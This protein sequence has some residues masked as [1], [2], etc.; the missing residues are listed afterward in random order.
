LINILYLYGANIFNILIIM[1]RP[2]IHIIST[3]RLLYML[4]LLCTCLMKGVA[5]YAQEKVVRVGWY[6]SPLCHKDSLGYRSG[7]AYEY[8]MKI[9][10]STKW[11]YEYVEG[12]WMELLQ[13][14]ERGEIDLLS[15]VSVSDERIKKMLFSQHEMGRDE[16]YIYTL[17]NNQ[18]IRRGNIA[19]LAGKRVGTVRKGIGDSMLRQWAANNDVQLTIVDTE[20][21]GGGLTEPLVSGKLDGVVIPSSV[22]RGEM[23]P[24]FLIGATQVF[25]AINKDRMDIKNELDLAMSQ[26]RYLSPLYTNNLYEKY[27][28]NAQH[29]SRVPDSEKRWFANHKTI[30]IGYRDDYMPFSAKDK[31]TG[32]IDGLL[33][34]FINL[35]KDAFD[36][37][38]FNIEAVAYTS[39]REALEAMKRG[40]VD[41]AFPLDLG[42]SEA[43]QEGLII[44]DALVNSVEMAI[45]RSDF[46]FKPHTNLRVAINSDNP[47]YLSIL[48]RNHPNWQIVNYSSTKDC[49]KGIANDE[50][51]LL[52][53]SNYRMGVLAE[54]I[55]DY[56]L[57]T[58]PTGMV[59]NY[60][61]ATKKENK[62]LYY[63]LY[64][65]MRMWDD[66][67]IQT[68]IIEHSDMR[69][70]P[71]I[72]DFVRD[73]W[74]LIFVSLFAI[75]IVISLLY[76]RSVIEH[77]K[78]ET[79][80]EA[81]TRFLFN[82]SHDIRTPMNAIIG[83]T[84][85]I[86]K[87]IQNKDAVLDY[88]KKVRMSSD[89]LLGII[90]NVLELA[91][92]E[93][94]K[95]EAH[96]QPEWTKDLPNA[97]CT[98]YGGLF[99]QKG[100]DFSIANDTHTEAI[101]CDKTK[102]NEIFLNLIS[103]AYKYT[104]TGGKVTV[105]I[106]EVKGCDPD[107]IVIETEIA[108][109]GI[110]ISKEFLPHLF[111]SFSRDEAA[112][113]K[114]IQGTGLGMPI[115]KNLI[116]MMGGTIRVESE[117]GK[118][119]TFFT[120][121]PFRVADAS[122]LIPIKEEQIDY[123][124]TKGKRILMAEDNDLNAE[125]A[126]AILEEVEYV[127]E[128]AT[129]GVECVKMLTDSEPGYYDIILMD[130]QM[131]NMDGYEATKTIRNMSD[132]TKASIPIVAM[133]ANAFEE[134]KLNA[135]K[136][137]MNDHL[138]KPIVV[139]ILMKVLAEQIG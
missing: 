104:P 6:E 66:A 42:V 112:T 136:V 55:R 89:L 37:I 75:T 67:D 11:K 32:E 29:L 3:L 85:L 8:Q 128:R 133:T 26:L 23:H 78:A 71:T 93:S 91:R 95:A 114:H 53:A 123:T 2:R 73:H 88:L 40:E 113:K 30:R 43:E 110:G 92:I 109:T 97:I 134:D 137:G 54:D 129:D 103:N 46:K 58:V 56:N 52:L 18:R 50:A 59:F 38:D 99:E 21:N 64:R 48:R 116:E 115:V 80:N 111:D 15:N 4:V 39:I 98:L 51:D 22:N 81:K 28:S 118:G 130:I 117:S 83:Y 107:H 34:D 47:T 70:T 35:A 132:K 36:N 74:V 9:A 139:P 106:K 5:A 1:L 16:Y 72:S 94:G 82:M 69:I 19:S 108:D 87:N 135:L 60:A 17:D 100:V 41:V 20:L 76:R 84:D 12:T 119:T 127:V 126:I 125:I 90:N 24:A 96:E 63:T 77:R 44:T 102:M 138:G 25:F 121:I 7:Y 13:K 65:L 27:F 86:R 57:K 68:S 122:S 120:S 131:P 124:A 33:K 10:I 101:Y 79:A 61:F 14:L 45:V 62:E 49:L 31:K 105:S